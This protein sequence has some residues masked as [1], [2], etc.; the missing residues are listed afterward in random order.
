MVDRCSMDFPQMPSVWR[1]RRQ[2]D[3]KMNLDMSTCPQ[4]DVLVGIKS[5]NAEKV[6]V[7]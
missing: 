6:L 1:Q 4:D 3:V 5:A 2:D 7:F